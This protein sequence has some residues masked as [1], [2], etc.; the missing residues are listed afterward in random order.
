MTTPKQAAFV[1]R[2]IEAIGVLQEH[3]KIG[4]R[5]PEAKA[6]RTCAS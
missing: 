1:D 2:L 3:P 6:A 5:V 4:R